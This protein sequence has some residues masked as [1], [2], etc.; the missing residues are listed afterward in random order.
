[1]TIAAHFRAAFVVLLL[2]SALV[3]PARAQHRPQDYETAEFWR[4]WGLPLIDA[5]YAY[6]LGADGSGV[7]VGIL[8][9]GIAPDIRELQ[10]RVAGGYDY[11]AGS[12]HLADAQGH[13]TAVASI[14]AGQRDGTLAS[15]A[16]ACGVAAGLDMAVAHAATLGLS[17]SGQIASQAQQH[18]F[19][20][21]LN[22]R[23]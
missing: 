2:S 15:Y 3:Q 5:Q 19:K 17:Y 18:G 21:N 12:P 22:V 23:F 8:D 11:V 10:G 13:G 6:M 9:S 14:I 7:R 4:S 16:N 20:A 1:M